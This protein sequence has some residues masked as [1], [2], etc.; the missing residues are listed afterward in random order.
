MNFED[1]SDLSL[2]RVL[3]HWSVT[4]SVLLVLFLVTPVLAQQTTGNIRG[5][6]KDPSG[7]V[8]PGAKVTV[9]DKNTNNSSTTQTTSEGEFRFNN[10]LV[11]EYQLKIEAPSF[12]TL[13]LSDVRVVLN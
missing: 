7:A 10:L 12:K 4:L 3:G 9:T 6:V 11:G 1:R 2:S 8:V 13:T 5:I